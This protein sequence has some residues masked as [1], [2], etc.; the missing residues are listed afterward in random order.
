MPTIHIIKHLKFIK[1]T[2]IS[3]G[4]ISIFLKY[5]GWIK[6]NGN[7]NL[8]YILS[9]EGEIMLKLYME[10]FNDDGKL[11]TKDML[12]YYCIET[13]KRFS[14]TTVEHLK[15]LGYETKT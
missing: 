15:T 11:S 12:N 9:A 1:Q 2:G 10:L 8:K 3:S 5:M 7:G 13:G 4:K 14:E 6:S